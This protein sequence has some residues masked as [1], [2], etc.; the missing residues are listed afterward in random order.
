MS[1]WGE[2]K[3]IE[4]RYKGYRFRSRSEA[5]WAVFFDACD[6]KWRYEP[7][8]FELPS[9]RYLPDFWLEGIKI[10]VEVKPTPHFDRW[11]M[12]ELVLATGHPCLTVEGLPSLTP[13]EDG[14]YYEL[15]HMSTHADRFT[16]V[17]GGLSKINGFSGDVRLG[18]CMRFAECLNC[19]VIGISQGGMIGSLHCGCSKTIDLGVLPL[20]HAPDTD[21]MLTAYEAARS[22]R[23]EYG[24]TP[25]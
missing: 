1:E 25:R 13:W 17:P 22:V 3:A 15:F 10:W 7:E 18:E 11:P 24:E 19:G 21:K 20:S 9:G 4:T 8:G 14:R 6:I 2:A 12:M 16:F 23:F 5:R